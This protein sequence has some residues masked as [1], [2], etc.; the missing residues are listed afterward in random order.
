MFPDGKAAVGASD[1]RDWLDGVS[2]KAFHHPITRI[3]DR[4]IFSNGHRATL[5]ISVPL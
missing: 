4:I 1:R 3:M 2:R 5:R